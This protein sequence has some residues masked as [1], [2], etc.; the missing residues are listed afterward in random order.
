MNKKHQNVKVT[1]IIFDRL[2]LFCIFLLLFYILYIKSILF[3]KVTILCNKFYILS[4]I[5][6]DLRFYILFFISSFIY[7]FQKC[8][9]IRI[10]I[11]RENK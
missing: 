6:F 7:L 2:L 1:K 4:F 3:K 10:S 5:Y 9:D 11:I 8:Q